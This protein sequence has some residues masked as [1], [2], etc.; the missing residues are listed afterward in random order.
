VRAVA[1]DAA[2]S[3]STKLGYTAIEYT[4]YDRRFNSSDPDVLFFGH[5]NGLERS[6]DGDQS[7]DP[8]R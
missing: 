5:H 3:R 7:G 4:R 1:T 6:D 8:A 2:I